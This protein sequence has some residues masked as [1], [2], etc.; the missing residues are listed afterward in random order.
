MIHKLQPKDFGK[1]HFQKYFVMVVSEPQLQ[2]L[3]FLKG[4]YNCC[5][6]KRLV[7]EDSERKAQK[8]FPRKE[9]DM[10]EVKVMNLDETNAKLPSMIDSTSNKHISLLF[11]LLP[12]HHHSVN[13]S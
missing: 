3:L 2:L 8:V 13:N 1:N 9:T 12:W 6:I 7:L 5:S 11:Q 4:T 10:N